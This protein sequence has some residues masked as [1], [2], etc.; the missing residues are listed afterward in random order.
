MQEESKTVVK[1]S[2][3]GSKKP[4]FECVATILNVYL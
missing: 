1:N 4:K 3:S 2:R